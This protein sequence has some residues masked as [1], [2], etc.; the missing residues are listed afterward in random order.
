[1]FKKYNLS[2]NRVFED[3]IHIMIGCAILA[4]GIN[5]FLAPNKISAGGISSIGTVLSHLFGIRM[6]L[7]NLFFNGILFVFGYKS[8]GR[9]AVIQT[10]FGIIA[11]SVFLEITSI[12]PIYTEN[13]MIS[14]LCGGVLM[15]AGVGIVVKRGASTGG[16]DFAGLMLK[17][18]FPH[19]SLARLIMIIDCTIVIISGVVFK[20]FTVTI[21]SILALFIS[22]IVTDKIMTVGDDAKV[23]RIFSSEL[24]KISDYILEQ[25]ERGVTGIHCTGMYSKSDSI[26][27]MC[28]VMPK[29]LPLYLKLIKEID[30]NA[31]II[32][33]DVHEVIGE[34]FKNIDKL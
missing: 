16:S 4:V 18:I 34:G 2:K 23:I 19:I 5:V 11:L 10:L 17:K 12:I 14:V 29:E 24:Q 26:M 22:S 1:M 8:L 30:K 25:F 6:S 27:L 15:G 7:T 9:Y 21:Y 32:I 33:G 3:L 13:D 28:V 31:F 20:S